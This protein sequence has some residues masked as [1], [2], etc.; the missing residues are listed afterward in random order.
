MK[1]IILLF[2]LSGPVT[3]DVNL[4]WDAPPVDPSLIKSYR[5]YCSVSPDGPW[6]LVASPAKTQTS[7]LVPAC[8]T[9]GVIYYAMKT[10]NMANVESETLSNKASVD[11]TPPAPPNIQAC[12][13]PVIT[14]IVG[15][16]SGRT[17]RPLY[18]NSFNAIGRV[19]FMDGDKPRACEAEPVVIKPGTSTKYRYATNAAGVR[20]LTICKEQ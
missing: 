4:R 3:A 14:Y 18:D 5:V 13:I 1:R 8:A 11:T 20:G 15:T 16:I 17:D 9:T 2:L 6:Q 10:V 7:A 12:P 19:E